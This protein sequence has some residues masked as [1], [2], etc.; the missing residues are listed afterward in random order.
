MTDPGCNND[1]LKN[2]STFWATAFLPNPYAFAARHAVFN[3]LQYTSIAF[4]MF[5]DR[6]EES[7]FIPY[8]ESKAAE[9]TITN[10]FGGFVPAP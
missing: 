6:S 1:L 4:R 9:L 8:N 5:Q 7:A 3:G 10:G 2:T